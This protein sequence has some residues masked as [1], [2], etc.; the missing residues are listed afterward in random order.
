[1]PFVYFVLKYGMLIK[2][3]YNVEMGKRLKMTVFGDIA[4][5]SLEKVSCV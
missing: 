3:D 1:M 5:C 4:V 2:Y